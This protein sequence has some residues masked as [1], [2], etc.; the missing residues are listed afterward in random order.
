MRLWTGHLARLALAPDLCLVH[1]AA[2][3]ARATRDASRRRLQQ[4]EQG[5]MDFLAPESPACRTPW[6]VIS[7]APEL[8]FLTTAALQAGLTSAR[9]S[10]QA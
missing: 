3:C 5:E 10:V 6:Q 9:P 1:A 8:S 4:G 7:G 2:S